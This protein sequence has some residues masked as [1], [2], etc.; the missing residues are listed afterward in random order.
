MAPSYPD[1]SLKASGSPRTG[2]QKGVTIFD[3]PE[4]IP[5]PN[6]NVFTDGQGNAVGTSPTLVA[7]HSP[8]LHRASI[9]GKKLTGRPALPS[10]NSHSSHL[11]P[12]GAPL[13]RPM[14]YF[15]LDDNNPPDSWSAGPGTTT[16]GTTAESKTPDLRTILTQVTDW[17][18]DEKAKRQKQRHRRHH[19]HHNKPPKT[20]DDQTDNSR[21]HEVAPD[22]EQDMSLQRLENILQNFSFTNTSKLL[23][24]SSSS[25]LRRGSLGKKYKQS[26]RSVPASSDTEFFGEDILVPNVEAKLDNT[27][28]MAFTGG[29]ADVDTSDSARRQDYEHWVTFKKDI[30][31]LTH[32]LKLKGWRR[33]PID[34]AADIDVARL[35]GALTN[36]VYV[37]HPP[38][39]MS[40]YDAHNPSD[41]S[42]PPVPVSRRRPT[43][44]LLRIYG[45][46]V[47]HLIDREAELGILRRLARKSIGP[48][49]L[50]SF[51][52]GRFE[53]FLNAKTL[54]AE[55]LRAPE[56]SKQIA[57]RM[58]ELHEGIDLLESELAAGPAVFVNWDKWVDRCEK[59]ISW[60]DEQVHQ[61]DKEVADGTARRKSRGN[62]RYVRRGLICGVEW[63][64]FR[65]AYDTYRQWLIE[66]CGGVEGIRDLLVFAHND[67]Q[68]G[69]LMRLQ[70][71]GT[72][73][74][75]RPSNQ[76]KQLV[77][78]DFEYAAQ[79]PVGLEFANHFTEWCYNYH[80]PPDKNFQCDTR[81]Y[82]N[83]QEQH[84]FVRSYVMHRPQFNPSA[85]ATP[86]M[87]AREKTNISDF[88]LDART[89]G[90]GVPNAWGG[91]SGFEGPAESDYDKEESERERAQEEEINRLL[92]QTRMWRVANSAQWVAWGIVQAKV[93]ELDALQ[94]NKATLKTMGQRIQERRR[95]VTEMISAGEKKVVEK[96]KG[97]VNKEGGDD[98]HQ[99][100]EH[101]YAMSDPLTEEEQRIQLESHWD[102]PEGRAQEEA[103]QEGNGDV[104]VR[105]PADTPDCHSTCDTTTEK[106]LEKN[107]DS[108]QAATADGG[109]KSDRPQHHQTEPQHNNDPT[110]TTSA[111]EDGA[112][113][114]DGDPDAGGDEPDEPEDEFDYLAYA[115]DRAM[116]FWGDCLR[117]G[118]VKESDL[119]RDLVQRAKIVP[120]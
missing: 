70:P 114:A 6:I 35:S 74:L 14:S 66:Q 97:L 28:T 85:S 18:Q 94:E 2:P 51:E 8:K 41:P 4:H 27:K 25:I 81:R 99:Q 103:H 17:L 3:E 55:D 98:K 26:P 56:T 34:R 88:M 10:S 61:V 79:N 30:V 47:E 75:L 91:S 110:D 36:A 48:R 38:K 112:S 7:L 102:R 101:A 58:R 113:H 80:N 9:S 111:R 119:P 105:H 54:T 115:Q 82:P 117:L 50:G 44:L 42:A 1:P 40:E 57:K 53:E 108:N 46:Q 60:L 5:E 45:P 69:N 76:H 19:H 24:K 39:D 118:L 32:T 63:P 20:P 78:I 43:S 68:Y 106:D 13:N 73:P 64:V 89:P 37:V 86:K 107:T 109:A 49:L 65:K 100:T 84:R 83:E 62:A 21:S 90:G 31:R 96:M 77:V 16:P 104:V 120:Y 95:S 11:S 15:S 52:N 23:H 92:Q 59:V 22:D 67:T 116:F 93:P 72:S 12:A 29:S 71:S 33:I 87:E